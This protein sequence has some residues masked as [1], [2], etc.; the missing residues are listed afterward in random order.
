[1]KIKQ[2]FKQL[3]F[4]LAAVV[5]LSMVSGTVAMAQSCG[6]DQNGNPIKTGVIDC[7]S[8]PDKDTNGDGT[9]DEKDID[10]N[11]IWRL[12]L[13]A[14]NV[15]TAG[16]GIAALGGIVYGAIL[17]T[18]AGGST[19]Q[20]KKALEFIRNVIIGLLAYALMFALLNFIIPGGLFSS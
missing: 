5:G 14:I 19:E 20:T 9:I 8:V 6:V 11:G 12:L 18:T 16:V 2:T 17:Y 4:G 7:S 3:L 13:I 1:M 15:L 10:Q